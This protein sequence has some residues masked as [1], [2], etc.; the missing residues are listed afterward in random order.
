MLIQTPSFSMRSLEN[1]RA[2]TL[3]PAHPASFID[4]TGLGQTTEHEMG[5]IGRPDQPFIE[6]VAQE[7]RQGEL[8][9]ELTINPRNPSN[10]EARGG[11]DT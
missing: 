2:F 5:T 3:K 11:I 6:S 10:R 4:K 8:F 9:L 7:S 1:A